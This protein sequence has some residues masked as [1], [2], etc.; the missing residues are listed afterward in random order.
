MPRNRLDLGINTAAFLFFVLVVF[1][2][3]TMGSA[4]GRSIFGLDR[5]AW[6]ELHEIGSYLLLTSITVHLLLHW[7][8]LRFMICGNQEA[9]R[10]RRQTGRWLLV[11]AA[12]TLLASVLVPKVLIPEQREQRPASEGPRER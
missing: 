12:L 9:S 2:G 10:L 3:F 6:G 1:S 7:K 4:H 8:W 11:M 5:H